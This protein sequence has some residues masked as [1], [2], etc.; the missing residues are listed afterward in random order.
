[1]TSAG[2]SVDGTATV[3]G[4]GSKW[5]NSGVLSMS[6]GK[7][8]VQCGGQ[9]ASADAYVGSYDG[10]GG[11]ATVTGS[12]SAWSN[13]GNLQIGDGGSSGTCNLTVADGGRV[14][15][16]SV[17]VISGSALRLRVSGNNMLTVG[18]TTTAGTVTNNGII[19]FCAGPLLAA[20][21]YS[22]IS[23][24]GGRPM[25]W[26]GSGTYTA[27]G[28]TWNNTAHTFTVVA[29]TSLAAGASDAVSSG[30]RLLFTDLGSGK[31]VGASFEVVAGGTSFSAVA[32][33]DEELDSLALTPGFAGPV[34]AGWDFATN[35]SGGEVL[36]SVEVGVGKGDLKV[37]HLAN[38][39]WSAYT[40][41]LLTYDGNGMASFTVTSFSG[42][43]VTAVPEPG[44][45]GVLVVGAMVGGRRR[46]V[47]K[48]LRV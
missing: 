20:G 3:S 44:M 47:G 30:E 23:D 25:T 10:A 36:L 19:G 37:W 27:F 22:P 4:A 45:V 43:A 2:G 5:L 15:A 24:C 40:P 38:G 46:R 39:S 32:M 6:D 34:Y 42:Y 18:T 17:N 9:I 7:L 35:Y 11:T 29:P 16:R 33:S 13:S 31:R 21:V 14:T 8:N 48:G 1:M 12:G 26:S 41:D 28:G